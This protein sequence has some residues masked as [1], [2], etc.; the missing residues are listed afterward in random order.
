[1]LESLTAEYKWRM[2]KDIHLI[3]DQ[4]AEGLDHKLKVIFGD[5]LV[6]SEVKGTYT[7]KIKAGAMETWFNLGYFP[8]EFELR[9][10]IAVFSDS[11]VFY[12]SDAGLQIYTLRGP[13]EAY[14]LDVKR[15]AMVL[16]PLTA[17]AYRQLVEKEI[18]SGQ[19]FE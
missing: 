5:N 14:I 7:C 15:S 11:S 2:T 6:P 3:L 13:A 16:D 19:R 12:F 17:D 9:A 8:E 1:M 10:K 4:V 18:A